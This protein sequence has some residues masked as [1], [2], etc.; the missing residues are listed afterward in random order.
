[1]TQNNELKW[2]NKKKNIWIEDQ[3]TK[4]PTIRAAWKW[5]HL[6]REVSIPCPCSLSMAR[7]AYVWGDLVWILYYIEQKVGFSALT[8]SF[9]LY[10]SMI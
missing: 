9:Q 2:K 8:G 6:A 3:K 5:N 1:M 7:K 10:D 4:I